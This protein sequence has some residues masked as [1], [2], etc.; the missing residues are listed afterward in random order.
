M[1]SREDAIRHRVC[2]SPD[3]GCDDCL[4]PQW[5]SYMLLPEVWELT[6]LPQYGALLCPSCCERR[7]GFEIEGRHLSDAP[8]NADYLTTRTDRKDA[9]K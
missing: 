8:C 4:T 1:T 3:G 5:E 6:G 9:T 7:L 2:M